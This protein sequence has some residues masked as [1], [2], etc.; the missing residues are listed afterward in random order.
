[1][2][3]LPEVETVCRT[4]DVCLTGRSIVAFELF[5][6][7]TLATP[8]LGAFRA[9]TVGQRVARVRRRAKLVVIELSSGDAI[10]VHLR[11]TGELRF[12]DA[13]IE[14]DEAR[15][16][17]LRARFELSGGT[18]LFFYDTRKFGR[19]ALTRATE[20][21][22]FF[23]RYGAE[24]LEPAFTA[25]ALHALLHARQR[26]T[27]PLLLDQTVI[28]GL[29]NIYVDESLF[30][31]GIHPLQRSDLIDIHATHALHS[32]IQHILTEA[33]ALRGSTF[34]DYRT[35]LGDIGGAQSRWLVYGQRPGTPCPRCG[36]PLERL[37]I[38]Q[39]GS[40]FCPRCQQLRD[41]R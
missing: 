30:A 41:P 13:T 18:R 20:R 17:Y 31:S 22:R 7:R 39:R 21:E 9:A 12:H 23:A 34:R 14:P 38:G 27:K 19:I 32:A 3:E 36:A 40:I 33:I 15:L 28:A 24:P 8:D 11:M 16:P 5:W 4:L 35:G 1:M 29:G 26:Q 6:P 2:P 10:T 37:V 25:N